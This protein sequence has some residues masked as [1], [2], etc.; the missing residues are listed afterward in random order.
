VVLQVSNRLLS[1]CPCSFRRLYW[2][3]IRRWFKCKWIR[4]TFLINLTAL[5]TMFA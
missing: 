2:N 1:H 3:P 4:F 5:P